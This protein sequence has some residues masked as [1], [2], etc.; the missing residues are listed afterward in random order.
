MSMGVLVLTAVAIQSPRQFFSKTLP[1]VVVQF[2]LTGLLPISALR[3]HN[4]PL[5]QLNSVV[6][7][8]LS[9]VNLIFFANRRLHFVVLGA[10]HALWLFACFFYRLARIKE[11]SP[12]AEEL[13]IG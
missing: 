2:S 13:G 8:A 4:Y 3:F 1:P 7:V 10:L 5:T 6:F 9:T 11:P 12:L